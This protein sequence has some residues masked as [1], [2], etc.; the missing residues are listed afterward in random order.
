MKPQ[1]R[2]VVLIPTVAAGFAAALFLIWPFRY[3]LLQFCPCQERL[4]EGTTELS[5]PD[6]AVAIQ[7]CSAGW[8]PVAEKSLFVAVLLLAVVVAGAIAWRIAPARKAA[9]G[10]IASVLALLFVAV[11]LFP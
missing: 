11:V 1:M 4:I 5:K 9:C 6:Y 10:L 2:W 7:S 8:F 3:L